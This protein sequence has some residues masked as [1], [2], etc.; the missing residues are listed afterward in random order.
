MR[1]G[2]G[3]LRHQIQSS[4]IAVHRKPCLIADREA[5]AS[6][7]AL[8]RRS[9]GFLDFRWYLQE[10]IKIEINLMLV[11]NASFIVDIKV[12]QFFRNLYI[13]DILYKKYNFTT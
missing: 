2:C 12:R 11:K 10:Y 13:N 8:K 6:A 1:Y 3:L 9:S 4:V 7:V 5:G